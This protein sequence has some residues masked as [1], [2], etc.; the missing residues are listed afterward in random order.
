MQIK[1]EHYAVSDDLETQKEM[2]QLVQV[3]V[4]PATAKTQ[5]NQRITNKPTRD[6]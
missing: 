4:L 3:R 6:F 5:P 2:M 1:D